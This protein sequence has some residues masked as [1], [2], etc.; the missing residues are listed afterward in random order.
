M[1][2]YLR[3]CLES[4]DKFTENLRIIHL[5]LEFWSRDLRIWHR[6]AVQSRVV[7]VYRGRSSR[8]GLPE[9][10]LVLPK[11][12]LRNSKTEKHLSTSNDY[13]ETR[14]ARYSILV[15]QCRCKVTMRRVP[16]T[17]VAVQKQFHI[18]W[19]FVCKRKYP[20]FNAHA[21]YCHL[22]LSGST[23]FFQIVSLIARFSEKN[24]YIYWT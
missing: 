12:K 24:I 8:F 22:G 16:T 7:I 10:M 23:T 2:F 1:R 18:F 5:P 17:F 3:I 6:S 19:E 15:R 21:P 11:A 4:T 20:I 13:S 14:K 9:K